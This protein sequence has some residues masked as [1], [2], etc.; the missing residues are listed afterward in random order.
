M[1]RFIFMLVSIVLI[2]T[3]SYIKAQDEQ[4]STTQKVPKT[5]LTQAEKD[6]I[7]FAKLSPEQLMELKRQELELESQKIEANS[8]EDM[9]LNG[10]GIVMI[11]MLPFL[12]VITI[13]TINVRRK[14][15]ESKRKY[16]LYMKSLEM[17]QTIPE[18]FFDEPQTGKASNLK[19]GIIS[20]MVGIAF[21]LYVII[22]KNTGLPFL[23]AALIPGFVGLG[24]LLVHFIEKPK[25][26]LPAEKQ[27]E[28]I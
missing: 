23:M 18:H 16:E 22:E 17:G 12:F 20:L 19:R 2:S 25:N 28:Q 9:P 14:N 13:V 5:E 24:Y 6:S 21:G 1:K 15:A 3:T 7:L 10:F 26:Q 27:D 4:D 11:V 8:R